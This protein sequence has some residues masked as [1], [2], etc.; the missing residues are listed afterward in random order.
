MHQDLA[1][2]LMAKH[3]ITLKPMKRIMAAKKF[4]AQQQG[5]LRVFAAGGLW[6]NR[7]CREAGCDV[8]KT[9][10]LSHAE[11]DTLKHRLYQCT[12]SEV[13]EARDKVI[14]RDRNFVERAADQDN[15]L[16]FEHGAGQCAEELAQTHGRTE[17]QTACDD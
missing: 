11:E 8:P 15:K 4:T 17:S 14:K 1:K 2:D 12:A 3:H 9:C 7:R 10:Q 6:T 5:L 16:L 13:K